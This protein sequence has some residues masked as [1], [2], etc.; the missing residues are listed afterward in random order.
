[1]RGVAKE[2]VTNGALTKA[3]KRLAV[4][5]AAHST[6]SRSAG[7]VTC[8]RVSAKGTKSCG[9]SAS[10]AKCKPPRGGTAAVGNS[11]SC[12][13]A[14]LPTLSEATLGDAQIQAAADTALNGVADPWGAGFGLVTARALAELGVRLDAAPTPAAQT[15]QASE[16]LVPQATTDCLHQYCD[17]LQGRPYAMYCGAP[18]NSETAP[19]SASYFWA[20]LPAGPCLNAA[21]YQHD[22]SSFQSCIYG[23]QDPWGQPHKH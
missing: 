20:Y 18:S 14:C 23:S 2:T 4:Q 21:C 12:Y 19:P 16:F 7:A 6:C 8:C 9:V 17:G 11:E 15:L 22:L 5:D 3:C 10:A 1:M 13:D